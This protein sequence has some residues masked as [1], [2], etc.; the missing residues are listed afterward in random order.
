MAI[1]VQDYIK[2]LAKMLLKINNG[3]NREAMRQMEDYVLSVVCLWPKH[4]RMKDWVVGTTWLTCWSLSRLSK[5]G[6]LSSSYTSIM[7]PCTK[8]YL[9]VSVEKKVHTSITQLQT[10]QT[11]SCRSPTLCNCSPTHTTFS[12]KSTWHHSKI[13]YKAEPFVTKALV[14]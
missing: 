7:S 8:S 9:L 12:L 5:V 13:S 11:D 6:W 3:E 4:H 1:L 14:L 2:E 10:L